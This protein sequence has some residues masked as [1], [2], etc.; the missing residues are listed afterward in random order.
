MRQTSAGKDIAYQD[1]ALRA[2][3]RKVVRAKPAALIITGDLT[4]NRARRS[5]ERLGRFLP[6]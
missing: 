2:F 5:A 4:F 1:L 3:V 6:P